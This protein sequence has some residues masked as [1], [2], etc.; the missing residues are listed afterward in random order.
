M[1]E[2]LLALVGWMNDWRCMVLL[3]RIVPT[4]TAY[5]EFS[6]IGKKDLRADP[7]PDRLARR[8]FKVAEGNFPAWDSILRRWIFGKP[9]SR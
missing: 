6:P 1:F 9:N 3:Y 5:L 8:A 4:I 7:W 2:R